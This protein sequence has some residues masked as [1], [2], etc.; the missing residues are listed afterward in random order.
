MTKKTG[1]GLIAMTHLAQLG[2]EGL[3]S[4][5]EIAE[6]YTIPL[7]LL[8]NILKELAAGGYVQSVRGARGGYRIAR[9]A[10]S[11]N[12]VELMEILEGPMKLAECI[13]G[14]VDDDAHSKCKLMPKCPIA[15]PVH[16]VH[17]K[18]RDFLSDLTL[19]DV[20]QPKTREPA[21]A[22]EG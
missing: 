17:R 8:M 14:E 15:D 21:V 7:A 22:G 12:F 11:V 13:R 1:Y 9:P 6:E 20:L 4:A 18:I 5:R 19:A 3:A 10:A 16:R 2:P